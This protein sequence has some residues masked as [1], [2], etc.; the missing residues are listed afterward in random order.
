MEQH[1][2]TFSLVVTDAVAADFAQG[3]QLELVTTLCLRHLPGRRT[4]WRASCQGR[5]VLLKVFDR[6]PKQERDASRE[7]FHSMGLHQAGLSTPAPLFRAKGGEGTLAVAFTFIPGGQTLSEVLADA[8]EAMLATGFRQ[9]LEMHGHQHRCGCYQSDDHLGNYLWS[10]GRIYMLD[11]GSCVL[12]QEVLG[13]GDRVKNMAMLTANISLAQRA[14]FDQVFPVYLDLC[15][16]EMDRAAFSQAMDSA[17]PQAIQKRL[18]SYLR[19]TRRS[20]SKL[21][22]ID[23]TGKSWH[24]LRA[25]DATLKSRL[26]DA[27][28][29]FFQGSVRKSERKDDGEHYSEVD[30]NHGGKSYILRHYPCPSWPYRARHYLA[31]PRVLDIWSAGHTLRMVGLAAALPVA[32]LVWKKYGAYAGGYLLLEKVAGQALD[33]AGDGS[34]Q[35][36]ILAGHLKALGVSCR[37]VLASDFIVDDS[38]RLT[39]VDTSSIRFHRSAGDL[40]EQL[41]A[42]SLKR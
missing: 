40:E 33:S 18:S 39:M 41:L 1:N 19:K 37:G 13:L 26:L 6:H 36:N 29:Q 38:G 24:A 14:V 35:L 28:G 12:K 30:V 27:P 17:V 42:L 23:F 15:P 2:K 34:R 8:D 3:D 7:W 25:I 11:A 16:D 20:S 9:L 10:D 4:V 32:C 5:D 31:T 21:E 22:Q